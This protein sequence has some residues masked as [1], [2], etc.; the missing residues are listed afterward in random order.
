MGLLAGTAAEHVK[1][2]GIAWSNW[3][4]RH[5][6]IARWHHWRSRLRALP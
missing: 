5:Q 6:A 4:R 1:T 2:L 3:R